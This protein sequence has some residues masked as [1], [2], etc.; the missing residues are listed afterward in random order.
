MSHP[1]VIGMESCGCITYAHANPEE[2]HR[3]DARALM[4]IVRA[5]GQV[6]HTTVEEAKAMPHFLEAKC[7]HEPKGWS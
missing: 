3:N 5:G 1:A 6:I 2:I 4:R 7:P